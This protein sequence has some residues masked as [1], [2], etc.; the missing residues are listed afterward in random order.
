[1]DKRSKRM[2]ESDRKMELRLR[3]ALKQVA[4]AGASGSLPMLD[5]QLPPKELVNRLI[6]KVR[7]L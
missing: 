4:D 2:F 5:G 3:V 6:A 7:R 1:M